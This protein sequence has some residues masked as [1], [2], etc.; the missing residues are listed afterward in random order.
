MS[1]GSAGRPRWVGTYGQRVTAARGSERRLLRILERSWVPMVMLDRERRFIEANTPARLTLRA[2]LAQL[3]SMRVEDLTPAEWMA[4]LEDA[5]RVMVANGC[6]FGP[7]SVAS[8]DGSLLPIHYFGIAEVIPD[9][10]LIAFVPADWPEHELLQMHD[11]P[12]NAPAVPLTPREIEV[13]QLAADGL[14][15][16]GIGDA[17]SLSTLTVSTHFS[18]LYAKLNVRDRAAAVAR[19]MRLGLI[20]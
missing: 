19:G 16:S 13:L 14:S 8:P 15:A 5:W 4:T 17:L 18:N 12:I 2:S 3:R 20:G 6:V 11:D 7:H 1:V 9:R 10:H